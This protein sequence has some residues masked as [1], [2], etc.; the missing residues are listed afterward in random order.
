MAKVHSTKN[1]GFSSHAFP[2]HFFSFFEDKMIYIARNWDVLFH[3]NKIGFVTAKSQN[4]NSLYPS[5]D[6]INLRII[7]RVKYFL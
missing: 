4:G 1:S 5:G 6:T 7:L 2:L 3:E